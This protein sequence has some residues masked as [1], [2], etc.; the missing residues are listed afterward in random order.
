MGDWAA[1][2]E[3]I[4]RPEW[5]DYHPDAEPVDDGP[6]RSLLAGMQQR[7]K[8]AAEPAAEPEDDEPEQDDYGEIVDPSFPAECLDVSG[9][10]REIT[11]YT[12]AK[13]RYPQPELALAGALALLGTI[14][15]RKVA[16]VLD[17]RTNVYVLGLGLSG[18]GQEQARQRRSV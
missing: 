14:T 12:L 2:S 5:Q 18:T 15:G 11:D 3:A 6:A 1:L 16:D 17:T 7:L 13:S 9:L 8:I 4:G 10:L